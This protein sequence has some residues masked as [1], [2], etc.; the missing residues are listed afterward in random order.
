V[1]AYPDRFI[2]YASVDPH[3]PE[4]VR[5]E[6]E[7]AFDELGLPLIKLHP[8]IVEYPISGPA[9]EP[10]WR[11]ASERRTVVLSHT[12]AGTSTC[13]PKLFEPLAEE[14]P[15]V[16]FVFGHS[17]GTPAGYVES[18]EIAQKHQNVYLDLCRSVMSGVWVERIVREVG[19]ERVLWG[20]DFP[21]I[22]PRYLVGR[23]ALAPLS[24]Q[25]KRLVLGESVERLLQERGVL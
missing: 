12:W 24:D 11:F 23:L 2:G 16:A 20:T 14:Y 15:D 4:R 3:H 19:P 8:T 18:I 25:A 22:E 5:P 7:R 17:G 13:A 1:R 10:V 6:L 9:Y 21:F